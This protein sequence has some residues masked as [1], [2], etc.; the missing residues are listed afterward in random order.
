MQKE[1]T[2]S[3]KGGYIHIWLF[4]VHPDSHIA[5]ASIGKG[6]IRNEPYACGF[7]FY[8]IRRG[9]QSTRSELSCSVNIE[10]G[11]AESEIDGLSIEFR[12]NGEREYVAIIY[13]LGAVDDGAAHDGYLARVLMH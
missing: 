2:R 8:L 12:R 3:Q 5:L 4:Y 9:I 1:Y 10:R 11:N 6:E 7:I 13:S